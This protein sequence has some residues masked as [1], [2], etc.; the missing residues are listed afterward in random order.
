MPLKRIDRDK[1]F[2]MVCDMQNNF[3][4]DTYCYEGVVSTAEAIIQACQLLKIPILIT[5]HMKK[6]ESHTMPCL[7]K[8]LHDNKHQPFIK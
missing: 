1:A 7:M 3:A 2:L 8:L 5:E 4:E 6:T